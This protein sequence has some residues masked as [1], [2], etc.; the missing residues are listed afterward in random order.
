[1]PYDI[2]P[3]IGID[4]EKEFKN[5]LSAINAQMKNFQSEM[6]ASVTSMEGMQ[7]AEEATAKKADI[8]GRSIE[9]G[10]QKIEL[11]Q[12]QYDRATEKLDQL[13]KALDAARRDFG[14][15]SDEALRAEQAY[16]RQAKAVNDLGTKLNNA[17]ADVNKMTKE[18]D[19]L[20]DEAEDAGGLMDKMRAALAKLNG[21][22]KDAEKQGVSLG[23]IFKGAFFANVAASALGKLKDVFKG[24]AQNMISAAAEYKAAASQFTQTFGEMEPEASAAVTEIAETTGI[25]PQRLKGAAASVYAF[26]RASGG[27]VSQSMD[28]M[29]RALAAAADSAA[30]YDKSLEDTTETLMSF[31]KGNFANDAALGVSATETT[32]N[33]AAMELFGKKYSELTEIQKQETLLK[34]VTD[35]QA[36]SGAMGQAAR[37]ADGWENVMGNLHAAWQNFLAQIG[38]PVVQSLTP[39]IQSL[40]EKLQEVV[41]RIDWERFSEVVSNILNFVIDNY[42]A[43][44]VALGVIAGGFAAVSIASSPLTLLLA[45]ITGIVAAVLELRKAMNEGWDSVPKWFE[46]AMKAIV[47]GSDAL[48]QAN[49]KARGE[50]D[51]TKQ[52]LRELENESTPV[53]DAYEDMATASIETSAAMGNAFLGAGQT[54][55]D[56]FSGIK[57]AGSDMKD[58]LAETAGILA[59][60]F[61]NAAQRVK[62]ALG[63]I[64]AKAQEIGGKIQTAFSSAIDAAKALPGKMLQIGIDLIRG[65]WEGIKSG[66][67]WLR[68][69]I[70]GFCQTVVQTVKNGFKI[71]SPSVLMRDEVGK[72]IPAGVAAGIDKAW[73]RMKK[74]LDKMSRSAVSVTEAMLGELE[75][76]EKRLT[77][78]LSVEGLD[79]GAKEALQA[80]LDA[81]KAYRTEFS[82]ALDDIERKEATFADKLRGYGELI[83]SFSGAALSEYGGMDALRADREELE[84]WGAALERLKSAGASDT[85]LADFLST[86][87]SKGTEYAAHL[88]QLPEELFREYMAQYDENAALQETIAQTRELEKERLTGL[89]NLNAEVD[90]LEEYS[91]LLESVKALGAPESLLSEIVGMDVKEAERYIAKLLALSADGFQAY[92][93]AWN[94]KQE[95]AQDIARRFYGDEMAQVARNMTMA[96][97]TVS[98]GD[99]ERVGA[100]IVNAGAAMAGGGNVTITVPLYLD[101]KEIAR[102]QLHDLIDVARQEGVALAW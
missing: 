6:K 97:P 56:A 3:R 64:G 17:K 45:A 78:A 101:G 38:T 98:A 102:A 22:M 68:E 83:D 51:L 34:M 57:T 90:A 44:G 8:L 30:Y 13:G 71:H 91:A 88:L 27:E 85:F 54:I 74:S 72:M 77:E 39:V 50:L 87:M 28:L 31:L 32:R 65:L 92:I 49:Q 59:K 7:S 24:V 20:G 86:D 18:L 67:G 15:N 11:I 63:T 26:A 76:Q 47:P 37:E 89:A 73:P 2:G 1:M 61:S 100:G 82:A 5:A 60:D 99:V 43:V 66:L 95:I 10:K 21:G 79:D 53:R 69:K 9:A 58:S 25:L 75:A 84:E 33:A 19:D 36:L 93:D 14:E 23:K 29:K 62:T 80:Q 42:K 48:V 81:V 96:I 55:R 41:N 46:A 35:A 16:N 12:G 70:S 52:K 40:T 94:S 4:G